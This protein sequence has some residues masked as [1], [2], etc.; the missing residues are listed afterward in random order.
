VVFLD[1]GTQKVNKH[2]YKKKDK[3]EEMPKMKMMLELK[4]T[5]PKPTCETRLEQLA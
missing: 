5:M 3:T 2:N 4:T 1:H